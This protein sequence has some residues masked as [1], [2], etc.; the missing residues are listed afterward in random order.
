MTAVAASSPAGTASTFTRPNPLIAKLSRVL[1]LS[2]GDQDALQAL[3]RDV[4]QVVAR[5]DIISDGDRPNGVHL[6]L[7]GW[8]CRYK[9]LRTG[10]R[11]ITALLLPGDFCD[12]HVTVLDRMDHAIGTI[13]VTKFAYVDRTQ[14]GTLTDKR[15]QILRALWW[16]TLVDEGVLRA[17]LVSMG[18][19]S[20]RERLAHLVCELL[21]RMHNIGL[22]PDNDFAMPLTQTDLGDALGLTSVHVNRVVKQLSADG[23]LAIRRGTTTVLDLPALTRI[24]DFDP[25][26]L[27]A[28]AIE[29]H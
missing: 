10:K 24:A 16:T 14:F 27:H 5:H 4:R 22:A 1:A 21:T 2:D 13:T 9:T 7:E 19:R 20:A 6:I 11:Q 17:W 15:S 18:A 26:Y 8:A 28:Q 12:L 25:S 3:C 23:V 29:D